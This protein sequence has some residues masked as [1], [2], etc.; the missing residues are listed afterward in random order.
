LYL[1]AKG[2]KNWNIQKTIACG[3]GGALGATATRGAVTS[4][5]RTN[6]IMI[7]KQ[8]KQQFIK[9]KTTRPTKLGNTYI[10]KT[11]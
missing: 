10:G 6:A 5:R 11:T 7:E 1:R 4:P 9:D 8:L 2:A 3:A